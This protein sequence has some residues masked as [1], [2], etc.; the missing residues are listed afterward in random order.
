M[1]K[2]KRPELLAPAGTLEKMKM[3]ILYGADAVY[4]GGQAFGLRALGGNFTDAELREAVAFAHARGKKV[5][6]TVNVYPHDGD[7]DGLPEYLRF[8][9]RIHVDALLVADLGVFS[10]A[11][12]VV[13]SLPLHVSTQANTVNVAAVRAWK[14]L[15][16]QR[17]VLARELSL[18]EIAAI[19]SAV[20]VELEMF[21]HGA[22]CISMSGRCLLSAYMTGRDA[23]RGACAQS[24]RW[25]YALMEEQ[26]PGEYFPIDEDEHG[27]YIMNS[28]DLCLLPYLT[29]V[30]ATGVDSLKIEGRM[31]SVHYV[32]SVTKAYRAAIDAYSADPAQFAINSAWTTELGK[33]SHRPY[34]TGFALHRA[35]ADDQIYG[36]SSYEQTSD[37]I[38]L[39]RSYDAATGWATVEQRNHMRVGE[40]IELFQPTLAGFRQ[41]LGEMTDE[42][43][44]P[45]DRAPHPQQIVHIRMEQP[46]EPY[47]IVR[48]DV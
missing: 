4:L 19:R 11:R 27:T 3:A 33:V 28:K 20:D 45:I 41:T 5:Y 47:A 6:V 43:G 34:T 8:L 29:D 18:R 9:E 42:A 23:N 1:T 32:A 14:A 26:R 46:V 30:I 24:C 22:M 48:R 17:V 21:V 12:D 37:F 13:P 36:S 39:V 40:E 7:M 25:R 35:T 16:A 2:Q 38:G 44:V 31:K 15:G 10:V